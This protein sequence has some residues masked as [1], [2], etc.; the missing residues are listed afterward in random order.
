MYNKVREVDNRLM[1]FSKTGTPNA[2]V[3]YEFPMLGGNNRYMDVGMFTFALVDS[4]VYR[5]NIKRNLPGR[6]IACVVRITRSYEC[7]ACRRKGKICEA[8]EPYWG[9]DSSIA[10]NFFSASRNRL[11]KLIDMTR[12]YLYAQPNR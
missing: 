10:R 5:N 12:N 1:L 3:R 11:Q 6:G 4:T 9:I 8:C 2:Y 7:D